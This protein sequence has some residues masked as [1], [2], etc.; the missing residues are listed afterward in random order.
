VKKLFFMLAASTVSLHA[1]YF[2]QSGALWGV[3]NDNGKI[4]VSPK[5]TAVNGGFVKD[6]PRYKTIRNGI[7]LMPPGAKFPKFTMPC[8]LSPKAEQLFV[9]AS[10]KKMI[11]GVGPSPPQDT[12]WH[13][14]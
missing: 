14:Q 6:W 8:C 11:F 13:A 2:F 10:L 3:S 9:S 7:S 5:Y 12:L 4:I 1:Q